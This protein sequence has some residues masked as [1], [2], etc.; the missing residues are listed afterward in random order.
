MGGAGRRSA[1]TRGLSPAMPPARTRGAP[2]RGGK[3]SRIRLRGRGLSGRSRQTAPALPCSAATAVLG[4]FISLYARQRTGGG[5]A[6][7]AA[8]LFLLYLGG[9]VG[10]VLGAGWRRAGTGCGWCGG[11]VPRA[12]RPS[13]V[14]S[15]SRGRPSSCSWRWPRPVSTSPSP[16]R[17]R[18]A[19]TT[20]PPTSASRAESPSVSPSASA[21]SP[22]PSSAPSP[23]RPRCAP[24]CCRSSPSL[25]SASPRWRR[26]GSRG[27][28]GPGGVNATRG[29]PHPRTM[30][31]APRGSGVLSP[32]R[33][34]A[35]ARPSP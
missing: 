28:S 17:S 25:S 33:R 19:R 24:P 32:R 6:V 10:T 20:C 27:R 8:A 35:R 30:W 4:A 34:P 18:W 16:S 5:A 1:F 31:T 11:P 13:R 9:A 2:G 22:G 21:V 7:G 3:G 26:R 14:W 29:G 23:T 12:C 15:S